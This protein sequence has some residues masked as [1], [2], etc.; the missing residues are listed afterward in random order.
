[1]DSVSVELVHYMSDWDFY[2]KYSASIVSSR[3]GYEW[4]PTVSF[5]LKWKTIP[6]LKVDENYRKTSD[7]KW[8]T[9]T[10]VYGKK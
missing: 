7:G 3:Q 10:S 9:T 8:Q 6:D 4:V 1:M 5:Y 2:C